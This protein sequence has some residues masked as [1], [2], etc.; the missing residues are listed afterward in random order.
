MTI[1][2]IIEKTCYPFNN[3]IADHEAV[4][5]DDTSKCI[6]NDIINITNSSSGKKLQ[7]FNHDRQQKTHFNHPYPPYSIHE[8]A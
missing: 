8:S 6:M 4:E 7:D 2:T 5:T 3:F 1:R